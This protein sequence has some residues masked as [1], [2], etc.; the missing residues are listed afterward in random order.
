MIQFEIDLLNKAQQSLAQECVEDQFPQKYTGSFPL[1]T[2]VAYP[3][4]VLN[5]TF[6]PS[7][8]VPSAPAPVSVDCHSTPESL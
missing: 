8:P 6:A 7:G 4:G 1:P 3:S 2:T 5:A